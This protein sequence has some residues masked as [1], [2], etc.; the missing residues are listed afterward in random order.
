MEVNIKLDNLRKR[1]L[2]LEN[3]AIAYSGGVDSNFLL[4][5]AKDTLKDK[6]IAVTLH[7]MMH[8]D[9]EIEES[10]NYAKEFGVN[11]IVLNVDNFKDQKI[12]ENNSDFNVEKDL[13]KGSKREDTL[14]Y[15]ISIDVALLNEVIKESYELDSIDEEELFDEYMTLSDELAM[16]LEEYMPEDVI[17]NARAYK[18]DNSDNTIKLV[19]AMAHLELGELKLSDI[20]RRLLTQVD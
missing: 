9:R 13:T 16:E 12:I 18:W 20:T 1:L 8:S 4:K 11:H 7:A 5:V 19:L 6:V 3:V 15:Q 14:A 2:E 17:I 10:K